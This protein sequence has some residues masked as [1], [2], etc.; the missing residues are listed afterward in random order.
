MILWKTRQFNMWKI[1]YAKGL[2]KMTKSNIS[3]KKQN[4][5]APISPSKSTVQRLPYY[6]RTLRRL[7]EQNILRVSST[8]LA[9]YM[10]VTASQVRQDLSSFGGFGLKGYGYDVNTLYTSILDLSGSRD[11]YSAVIVGTKEMIG[12]LTARP[13][14][15]KQGVALKKTFEVGSDAKANDAVLAEFESYCSHTPIDIAVL[16]TYND[17]TVKAVDIIKRLSFK[18]VWN[19]S[20]VK[21]DLDLPVKNIWIDD[22]LMTLCFELSRTESSD[23]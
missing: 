13:V 23:K 19:F 5:T 10:N 16:A 1:L 22:S 2:E 12:M 17:D 6:L 4:K 15:V 11:E 14:F 8:E 20:D 7:I 18:G 9:R 3:T 21:L